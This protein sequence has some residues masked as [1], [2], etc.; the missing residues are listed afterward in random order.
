MWNSHKT[1]MHFRWIRG[2]TSETE[3]ENT[4]TLFL[5]IFFSSFHRYYPPYF[6]SFFQRKQENWAIVS[7]CTQCGTLRP[8]SPRG[9]SNTH[10]L[11]ICFK[12]FCYEYRWC[13]RDFV[14][15]C[16]NENEYLLPHNYHDPDA[17]MP[18]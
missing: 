6:R 15:A 14:Y 8:K 11:Y 12:I 10:S 9:H 1:T 13:I 7:R 2:S 16:I 4:S 5:S 17:A 18:S 3:G